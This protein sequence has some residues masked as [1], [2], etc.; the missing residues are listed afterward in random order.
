MTL[1]DL[2]PTNLDRLR[3]SFDYARSP[4]ELEATSPWTHGRSQPVI[5]YIVP[6]RRTRAELMALTLARVRD[7]EPREPPAVRLARNSAF[8]A[9]VRPSTREDTVPL[10]PLPPNWPAIWKPP[11]ATLV[12]SVHKTQCQGAY[13]VTQQP[14]GRPQL[15]LSHLA[16]H[17]RLLEFMVPLRVAPHGSL[18]RIKFKPGDRATHRFNPADTS[19]Q[20]VGVASDSAGVLT[21]NVLTQMI[22]VAL[23][24]QNFRNGSPTC[25]NRVYTMYLPFPINVRAFIAG[26]RQIVDEPTKFEFT[27]ARPPIEDTTSVRLLI[28]PSGVAVCVG[29]SAQDQMLRSMAYFLPRVFQARVTTPATQGT[30]RKRASSSSIR[31]DD[32]QSK[33][34]RR[35]K[36]ADADS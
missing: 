34:H 32:R 30:K 7:A 29:A 22:A 6:P 19:F 10:S 13:A 1:R 36:N 16:I 35:A 5:Q 28:F 18:F 11:L 4:E 21:G 12:N 15:A 24:L 9:S 25:F 17:Q 33:R 31:H 20:S 8:L 23:G 26:N 14:L 3:Y 27:V 2:L